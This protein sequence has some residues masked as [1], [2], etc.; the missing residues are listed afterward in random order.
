MSQQFF[1]R[2][3]VTKCHQLS[4]ADAV[5]Q[6]R[7]ATYQWAEGWALFHGSWVILRKRGVICSAVEYIDNIKP[8]GFGNLGIWRSRDLKT[9]G[10]GHL[11]IWRFLDLETWGLR[12]LV[13]LETCGFGGLVDLE[14]SGFGDIGI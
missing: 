6:G 11:G 10:F 4:L 13:D 1:S 2:R 3:V 9:S 8:S 14:T 12:G 7:T 5:P